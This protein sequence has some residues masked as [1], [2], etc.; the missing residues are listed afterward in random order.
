MFLE[1]PIV[2]NGNNEGKELKPIRVNLDQVVDY[3]EWVEDGNKRTVFFFTKNSGKSKVVADIE[4]S[5]IDKLIGTA[6]L[7]NDE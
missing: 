3:R 7:L 2:S 1:V 4:V 6:K 5:K